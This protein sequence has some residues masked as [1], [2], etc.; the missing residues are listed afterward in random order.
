MRPLQNLPE[1][2]Q[3]EKNRCADVGREETRDVPVG[4][5]FAHEDVE[6]V[7]DDD[8]DEEPEGSPG[9]VGLEGRFEDEGV[10]VY[11]LGGE[12]FVELDV[13]YADTAPGEETGDCC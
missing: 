5:V 9:E 2:I 8:D 3:Q 11:A 7:E 12:G 13:G 4:I 1:N 6:A 10:S